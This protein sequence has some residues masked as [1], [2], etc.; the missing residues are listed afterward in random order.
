[1]ECYY[2][3]ERESTD[4]C[5]ICGKSICKE[6]GL[7]IAGKIYCKECLEK[8]VGLG[9]D[10]KATEPVQNEVAPEPL[11]TEPA[12]LNKKVP[13]EDIYPSQPET[14]QIP[15][16]EKP[17]VEPVH[18]IKQIRDDSPYNIK[19]NY[20][21]EDIVEPS[22]EPVE[23]PVVEPSAEPIVEPQAIEE[24]QISQKP[25]ITQDNVNDES[26]E[27]IYPDHTY[28]PEPTNARMELED[29]YEKYLDDLYFDEEE[30]PL[31]EQL[32]KDEEEFGS[33]TRKE[34]PSNEEKSL[35][36]EKAPGLKPKKSETPEEM[37]ARLRAEILEEKDGKKSD[38][39][40]NLNYQNEKESMGAVDILLT[41]ILIIV[42]LV[43]IYYIIYIFMLKASYPTFMEAIYGLS[44]PQN[45]I[46][47]IL[48]PPPQ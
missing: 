5:A 44:N 38:S 10:N 23:E 13:A 11:R 2:H 17:N 8:I 37:E 26:A 21:N 16:D 7:E 22:A 19:N 31:G 15:A 24:P 48:T 46:N 34:Y 9:I 47:N 41:I 45:V 12:R 20:E 4:T 28:E 40:H 36:E 39:I 30:V 32:A 43:V 42:I 14:S 6:C 25:Q 33:L 27:Y 1:M 3:P 18:E 35:K 29:K